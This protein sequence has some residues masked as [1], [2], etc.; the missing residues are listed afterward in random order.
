MASVPCD[1]YCHVNAM[2]CFRPSA[3]SPIV[4]TE[5]GLPEHKSWQCQGLGSALQGG[6]GAQGLLGW[7]EAGWIQAVSS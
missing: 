6:A 2:V 1:P 4:L 5:P 7:E 3:L